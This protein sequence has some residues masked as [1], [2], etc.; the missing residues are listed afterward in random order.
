MAILAWVRA[1]TSGLTLTATGAT[2]PS[3]A[4]T[5][6]SASSSGSLST[7]NCR[8]PPSSASRIS[9]RVLP[10]PEKTIRS[11]GTPAARARRYSPSLTTSIPAPSEPISASTARLELAFTA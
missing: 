9:S 5:S 8:T 1:S 4:A 2:R 10:T 6:L 3:P 7:L 11:P